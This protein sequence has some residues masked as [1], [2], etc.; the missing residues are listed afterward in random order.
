MYQLIF[1]VNNGWPFPGIVGRTKNDYCVRV[2]VFLY[3]WRFLLIMCSS[4]LLLPSSLIFSFISIYI[5]M[6]LYIILYCDIYDKILNLRLRFD[7]FNL[8]F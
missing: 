1:I 3:C 7:I 8:R 5:Y 6:I 2:G 4:S